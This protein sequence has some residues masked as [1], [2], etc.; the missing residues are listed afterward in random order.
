MDDQFFIGAGIGYQ[1]NAWLRGDVTAEYRSKA[2]IR[3]VD[4]FA[5]T[6]SDCCGT[7]GFDGSNYFNTTYSAAVGLANLYVDLGN[8]YGLSPF[9]GVGLGFAYNRLSGVT[10]HGFAAGGYPVPRLWTP[11]YSGTGGHGLDNN[12]TQFAWAL[13]AGLAYE[14]N[15]RLKL[16]LAYRYL[17]LGKAETGPIIC[18][19]TCDRYVAKVKDL[20]S[21]DLKLGMRWMLAEPV[22]VA[23]PIE[24]PLIRKY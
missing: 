12:K 1:F 5:G 11:S 3:T 21:H 14:V 22:P 20:D 13:H 23:A 24:Q 16:E 7:F 18:Y 2:Q 8:W 15:P 9:F 17:D 19:A 4:Q 10:D 6:W